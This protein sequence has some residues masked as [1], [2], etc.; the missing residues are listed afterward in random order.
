MTIMQKHYY[1]TRKTDNIFFCLVKRSAVFNVLFQPERWE[2]WKVLAD[3][4]EQAMDTAKYHFYG[5]R[6]NEILVTNNPV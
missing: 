5:S 6:D 4:H 3:S 2:M 1:S